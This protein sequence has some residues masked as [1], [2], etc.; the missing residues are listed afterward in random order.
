MAN[1]RCGNI[2]KELM[3]IFGV[4]LLGAGAL[5]YFSDKIPKGGERALT[6]EEII[7]MQIEELDKL[8]QE[9]AANP[10]TE[11][12]KKK[13]MDELDKLRKESEA[14]PLSQEEI[15]K[16]IEELNKLRTQQ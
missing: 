1:W 16:Q 12:D 8:R 6:Q 2:K 13:Q 3:I 5:L 15:N 14:K 9:A 7:R 10:L 4:L 11:E